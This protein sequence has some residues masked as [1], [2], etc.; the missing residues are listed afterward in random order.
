MIQHDQQSRWKA[1][2]RMLAVDI[3]PISM[4]M[5]RRSTSLSIGVTKPG[6]LS[7]ARRPSVGRPDL[8]LA[9]IPPAHETRHCS[10]PPASHPIR[11]RP[12]PSDISQLRGSAMGLTS[13]LLRR[14]R[15]ISQH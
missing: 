5:L 2:M 9:L 11:A 3:G 7:A 13:L 14:L 8:R 4:S 1:W 6:V 15:L 10:S 12:Y